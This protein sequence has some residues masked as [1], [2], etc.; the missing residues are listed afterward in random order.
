M[1]ATVSGS[2]IGTRSASRSFPEATGSGSS[3]LTLHEHSSEG[4]LAR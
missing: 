3:V 4:A 1:S 2:L